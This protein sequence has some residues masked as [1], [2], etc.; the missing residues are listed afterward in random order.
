MLIYCNTYSQAFES[1]AYSN[2]IYIFCGFDIPKHF[3]YEVERKTE[4]G[5]WAVI[6]NI[7]APKSEAAVKSKYL[8]LPNSIAKLS[9]V[10]NQQLKMVWQ[11]VEKSILL[12]SLYFYAADPRIQS[13]VGCGF[14]DED[15]NNS[16]TYEY[17]VSKVN[18]SSKRTLLNEFAIKFPATP[19]E[20]RL[21]LK[22]FSPN[23]QSISISYEIS[24][25]DFMA[26]VSL[27]R[28]PYLVN[29][30]KEVASNVQFI[31]E[32]D[33]VMANVVDTSVADGLAYSY[34]AKP[35]TPLGNYGVASDTVN[36][37]NLR[38]TP[39]IGLIT[40][41]KAIADV[42]K[43]GVQLNW[44]LKTDLHITSIDIY[45]SREYEKYYQKI[46]SVS[47]SENGYL[48]NV[49]LE[50]TK[51]Y[52]YYIVANNG[53]GYNQPSAR[54]PVILKGTK[55]N[56]LPPQH[57]KA[58]L[59]DNL[60]TL[61][62]SKVEDDTRGYYVYRAKGYTGQLEQLPRMV[63]STDSI[64]SYTDT[65]K[66]STNFEV[67]SY[68]VADI[69]TSYN[70]SPITDRVSVKFSGGMLPIPTSLNA[71]LRDKKTLLV[72]DNVSEQNPAVSA[73]NI[74]RTTYNE[75]DDIVEPEKII[76][77][78]SSFGNSFIDST[79]QQGHH[80]IYKVQSV[81]F[82]NEL[83]SPSLQAGI[84]LPLQLP[85]R[86]GKIMAM[87]STN[88]ILL[89][90][91][92]PIDSSVAKVKV[93]RT[94]ANEKASLLVELPA[95]QSSYEDTSASINTMYFYYVVTENKNGLESRYGDPVSAKIR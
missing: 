34:Y 80:Y 71:M 78:V 88:K 6:A 40:E 9:K 70:L 69:N 92:L 21:K 79:V 95:N 28:S 25:S 11:Q 53:Y 91:D 14:F 82:N 29:N 46:A 43:Q 93:Y 76:S 89:Q 63:L 42:P 56:L 60:V 68:A 16:G 22:Q 8:D 81:S 87:S 66:L 7:N 59:K 10:N 84:T 57:L 4:T 67:Y 1:N 27:Y 45:R 30:Y 44:K 33:I 12:D 5:E 47:P 3:T 64:I 2:G 35:F 39:D 72:W 23:G 49:Q 83:S 37:Y 55:I 17:K 48:D 74:L 24:D 50:P 73:Y 65:L 58:E 26:G 36:I 54:T 41:F 15:I 62:F 52:Y 19:Y 86:P 85:L 94:V 61:S 32:N 20:G 77:K 18:R 90:W 38:K 13:V 75:K 51:A 31:N